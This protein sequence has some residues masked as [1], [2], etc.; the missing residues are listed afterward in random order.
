VRLDSS[1]EVSMVTYD[2][3]ATGNLYIISIKINN[4]ALELRQRHL[5][6]CL[7]IKCSNKTPDGISGVLLLILYFLFQKHELLIIDTVTRLQAIDINAAGE[8]RS[9]ECKLMITGFQFSIN[10]SGNFLTERIIYL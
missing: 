6:L 3:R 7:I 2:I 1:S 4:N 8:V 9:I 10:Q 5:I